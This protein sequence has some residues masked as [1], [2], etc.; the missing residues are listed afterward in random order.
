M[1]ICPAIIGDSIAVGIGQTMKCPSIAHISAVSSS[2][3][4]LKEIP[5]ENT[6]IISIGS[7]D[8]S[9]PKLGRNLADFRQRLAG[10]KV[11]WVIPYHMDAAIHVYRIAEQFADTTINLSDYP[12]KDGVHPNYPELSDDLYHEMVG[13][14]Q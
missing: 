11:I 3:Y 2:L 7:N 13:K 9:N 1:F 10:K 6:V 12:T 14:N 4:R 8:G 5:S